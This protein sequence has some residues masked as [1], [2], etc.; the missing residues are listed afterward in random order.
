M[1]APDHELR[2]NDVER[3]WQGTLALMSVRRAARVRRR[4]WASYAAVVAV[5]WIAAWALG[6]ARVPPRTVE[7][8]AVAQLEGSTHQRFA[9][10][11]VV[12]LQDGLLTP[13]EDAQ[14]R[15]RFALRSGRVTVDAAPGEPWVLDSEL[16]RIEIV[17]S[18]F[19]VTHT[20][21]ALTIELERGEAVVYRKYDP[22]ALRLLAGGR[23]VVTAPATEE[24]AEAQAE[25]PRIAGPPQGARV[26]PRGEAPVTSL[27]GAAA[28]PR[29]LGTSPAASLSGGPSPEE[30]DADVPGGAPRLAMGEDSEAPGRTELDLADAARERGDFRLA[31][32]LYLRGA[33]MTLSRERASSAAFSAGR[34]LFDE[35]ADYVAAGDA[36]ELAL[37]LGLGDGGED[38]AMAR[39]AESYRRGGHRER[40][41]RWAY[42][43]LDRAPNG[44]Y[45]ASLRTWVDRR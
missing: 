32:K 19:S 44:P 2:P 16:A 36:F 30:T 18:R 28:P 17:G 34:I 23:L 5:V 11:S 39:A 27:A 40:A 7:G 24:V 20:D 12:E 4:R 41:A 21:D 45:A 25:V 22:G 8:H 9:D 15:A 26:E 42:R 3:M 6:R 31:A 29:P 13:V 38:V 35:L 10:G 37:E 1:R 14:G 33:R 43:Y